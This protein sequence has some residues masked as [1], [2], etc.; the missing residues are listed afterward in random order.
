V[1]LATAATALAGDIAAVTAAIGR[2]RLAGRAPEDGPAHREA[3]AAIARL[4]Q[5]Y[6]R[7]VNEERV[8]S[9]T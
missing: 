4:R 2:V 6:Q 9:P 8:L 1:G 7:L 5:T 3:A